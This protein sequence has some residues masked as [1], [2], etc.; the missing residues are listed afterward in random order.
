[1]GQDM[2]PVPR[3]PGHS[4]PTHLGSH[5]QPSGDE[6]PPDSRSGIHIPTNEVL[7]FVLVPSLPGFLILLVF[8]IERYS[9]GGS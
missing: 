3:F 6:Y 7:P 8:A 1:M 2:Y 9:F 5:S 4:S